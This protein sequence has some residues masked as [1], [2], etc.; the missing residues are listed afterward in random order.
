MPLAGPR[1][2][3]V[4]VPIEN[5]GPSRRRRVSYFGPGFFAVD[6][7]NCDRPP[8]PKTV[9]PPPCGTTGL[10]AGPGPLDCR[11]CVSS[12][13]ARVRPPPREYAGADRT[14]DSTCDDQR[15]ASYV[16]TAITVQMGRGG[17]AGDNDRLRIVRRAVPSYQKHSA[18]TC[19][20]PN[21]SVRQAG[22]HG[23]LLARQRQPLLRVLAA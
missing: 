20:C 7:S 8:V 23:R 1:P 15:R 4:D 22:G 17:V 13:A 2:P 16:A 10:Y 9:R 12:T 14:S 21:I 11:V 6:A 5:A 19:L 18:F 3:R